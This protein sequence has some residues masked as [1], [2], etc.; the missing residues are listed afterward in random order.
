MATLP[1]LTRTIDDAF[2]RTWYEIKKEATDNI[3][4]AN[5]VW[6]ALKAAGCFKPQRGGDY[7]NR[8]IRYGQETS[9]S[10]A[11]GD[12]FPQGEPALKTA[13]QWSWRYEAAHVQRSLFDDQTNAGKYKIVSYIDDRMQAARE[14]LQTS[15]ETDLLGAFSTTAE[16]TDKTI[17]GLNE[18]VPTTRAN[19]IDTTNTYGKIA[20]PTAMAANAS[21]T[22]V[23]S[24]GNTWWGPKYQVLTDPG[25]VNLLDDM[26]KLY[27]S[28]SNNQMAPNLIITDQAFFELFTNF[29]LD[30]TQIVKESD[31]HLADL[32]YD[33][34]RFRGKT[35]VWTPNLYISSY[36]HMLM[37][38]TNFIE[39]IYDPGLWF[40][41]T[42]WKPIPLQ[43]ERIAHILCALNVIS[44]QQRRHGRL[45]DEA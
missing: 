45:I 28:I 37:L 24:T 39:V 30:Q 36:S 4:D 29:A 16:M 23:P 26:N 7:I 44:T 17:Q 10:V 5:V 19:A 38:N 6:A 1:S 9:T 22:Y 21:G 13:A 42:E 41:M 35:L 34:L 12:V 43:G 15:F 40:D 11:K 27:N 25:E 32:G 8:T 2:I 20:R 33:V 18:M 31:T 14:A 3:L